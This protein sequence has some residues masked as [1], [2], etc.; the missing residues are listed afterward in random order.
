MNSK[1]IS[2]SAHSTGKLIIG[3]ILTTAPQYTHYD[4]R[5]HDCRNSKTSLTA[6]Y[7]QHRKL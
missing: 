5:L 2:I 4:R 7:V 3:K 6:V 1:L